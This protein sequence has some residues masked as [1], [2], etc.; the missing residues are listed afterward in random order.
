LSDFQCEYTTTVVS[1]N[2]TTKE[3]NST[4]DLV[5]IQDE[6]QIEKAMGFLKP[7]GF[8]LLDSNGKYQITLNDNIPK[9][10][11]LIS[12]KLSAD[13]H[14]MLFRKVSWNCEL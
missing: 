6:A 5:L 7:S 12:N 14:V 1:L 8:V 3:P 4:A 10:A 13:G 2:S 9:S 11:D